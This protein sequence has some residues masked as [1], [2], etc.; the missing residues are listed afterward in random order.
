MQRK[1]INW[2]D[3]A[4]VICIWL[5]VVCHS[6]QRGMILTI[7]HQFFMPAFFIISGI[8]YRP[9][10]V[11]NTLISFG[12][13]ILLFGTI[14]IVYYIGKM[15][16]QWKH[17]ALLYADAEA[18]T[19]AEMCWGTAINWLK[20]FIFSS[21]PSVFRGYWFVATLLFLRLLYEVNVVRR[22]KVAIAVACILWCCAEPFLPVP[23]T[24]VSFRPYMVISCLPFFT[25]GILLTEYKVDV[26]KGSFE[27]KILISCIFFIL[28]LIQGRPDMS[29]HQYGLT[30]AV[31]FI[32]AL[33]GSYI[34]FDICA[35][36]PQNRK[37]LI[38]LSN[39]T[40]LILGTHGW[41]CPYVKKILSL[42]VLHTSSPY[43]PL[44]VGIITLAICYPVIV[45]ADKKYPLVLGKLRPKAV[46]IDSPNTKVADQ[47]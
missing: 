6:G 32:N 31:F 40:L 28:T 18:L 30:Y 20:S 8:L 43:L 9:K 19:F 29:L 12:F 26:M 36:A 1:R 27:W 16:L 21:S 39:G 22:Y 46:K 11:K 33:L 4:K 42:P 47:K 34:L 15:Y 17:G 13:P 5:L 2:I 23:S 25:I 37:W 7:T 3:L 24:L 10:G 41:I 14:Y 44:F 45:W 35:N 38:H